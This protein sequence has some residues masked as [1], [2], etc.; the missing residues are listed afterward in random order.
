MTRTA[1]TTA[2]LLL[3]GVLA[4]LDVVTVLLA[5]GGFPPFEVAVAA[6]A[7]GVV[8]LVLLVPAWRGGRV[9]LRWLV[10]LRMVSALTSVP[11]LVVDGVPAPVRTGV[12]CVLVLTL[13]GCALVLPVLRP[14]PA[15]RP[16]R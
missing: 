3:L 15:G 9:A 16:P 4:V 12:V 13:L 1:V 6:G 14:A 2:G 8:S 5:G 11:A 10:G 7:L